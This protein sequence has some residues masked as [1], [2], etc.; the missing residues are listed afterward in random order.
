MANKTLRRFP[1]RRLHFNALSTLAHL[2]INVIQGEAHKRDSSLDSVGHNVSEIPRGQQGA[3]GRV[4]PISRAYASHGSHRIQRRP[5]LQACPRHSVDQ[6]MVPDFAARMPMRAAQQD[7]VASAAEGSIF[8]SIRLRL[9]DGACL[10]ENLLVGFQRAS[11][12]RAWVQ[13]A[14]VV[15]CPRHSRQS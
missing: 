1:L 7:D 12:W 3:G 10:R 11:R 6:K 13:D 2:S 9:R 14:S 15:S 8:S 5:H 4:H